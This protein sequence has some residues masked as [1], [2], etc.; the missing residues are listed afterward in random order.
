MKDENGF[1]FLMETIFKN[2]KGIHLTDHSEV[3]IEFQSYL[4]NK[5]IDDLGNYKNEF[6]VY[7]NIKNQE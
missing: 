1:P 2:S 4:N 7:E 6:K 5:W 3:E